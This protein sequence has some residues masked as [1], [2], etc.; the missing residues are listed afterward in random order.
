MGLFN[1]ASDNNRQDEVVIDAPKEDSSGETRLGKEVETSLID[2]SEQESKSG[3]NSGSDISLE[4]VHRQNETII[5]LLEQIVDKKDSKSSNTRATDRT[6]S[7]NSDRITDRD[8]KSSSRVT[9]RKDS[10][11]DDSIGDGMNEL[12]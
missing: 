12:L 6:G 1:D 2:D 10:S 11:N 5:D 8:S 4:D 7:R 3:K 9:D